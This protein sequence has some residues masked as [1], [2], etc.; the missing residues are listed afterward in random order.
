MICCSLNSIMPVSVPRLSF[1]GQLTCDYES[2]AFWVFA[3]TVAKIK[4]R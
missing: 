3:I 4:G 1:V 2:I